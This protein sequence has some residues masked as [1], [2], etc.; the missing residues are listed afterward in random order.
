[1]GIKQWWLDAACYGI[2][3]VFFFPE[4]GQIT[5]KIDVI[6]GRCPV[7]VDCL[8]YAMEMERGMAE[9]NRFGIWGGRTPAQRAKLQSLRS[10]ERKSA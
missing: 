3:D 4:S 10:R 1:M 9:R 7:R 2:P 6:C 5:K 8:E